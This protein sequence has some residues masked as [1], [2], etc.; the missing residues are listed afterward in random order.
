MRAAFTLL[1]FL[2][3]LVQSAHAAEQPDKAKLKELLRLPRMH[4]GFAGVNPSRSRLG[5]AIK[6]SLTDPKAEIE[7]LERSLKGDATDAERWLQLGDLYDDVDNQER[8]R[9]AFVKAVESY[10][11]LS[12]GRP[13]DG[14]LLMRL[15]Q[16]LDGTKR[17]EEAETALRQA[18]ELSPEDERCWLGLAFFL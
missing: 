8:S 7:R 14:F 13:G 17:E 2:L 12:Q 6:D 5:F 18:V 11:R 1:A 15:G 16:S 10:R 9:E 4:V 3:P